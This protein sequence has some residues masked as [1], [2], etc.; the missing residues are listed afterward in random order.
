[1]MISSDCGLRVLPEA[2]EKTAARRTNYTRVLCLSL[3][4]LLSAA[5]LGCVFMYRGLRSANAAA[6]ALYQA[7]TV[8][9]PAGEVG[10][11]EPDG[12]YCVHVSEINALVFQ[13]ETLAFRLSSLEYPHTYSQA[14][15]PVPEAG[16]T[17]HYG[18]GG[19]AVF[20]LHSG[21]GMPLFEKLD[22][23]LG[24]LD[25]VNLHINSMESRLAALTAEIETRQ[26]YIPHCWPVQTQP[27]MIS[28]PFG[29]RTDPISGEEYEF[30]S[31]LDIAAAPGTEIYASASGTVIDAS[32][33]DD[34]GN[35][36]LIDHGGGFMTR[37]SHCSEL[38]VCQGDEV[39]QGQLIASVGSTGRST[40]PHCDFRVY[41]DGAAIDPLEILDSAE[42]FFIR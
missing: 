14:A 25:Y 7:Q 41:S 22:Y 29:W 35:T 30:H 3:A 31:G 21:A 6:A 10:S 4:A 20:R 28:S 37:Y 1:M 11:A 24:L 36:I 18:A 12:V 23:A 17:A 26:E 42:L 2:A 32:E 16:F 15:A 33:L 13:A 9:S 5:L 40:G 38:L 27:R 8:S 34:Y 19:P 39:S